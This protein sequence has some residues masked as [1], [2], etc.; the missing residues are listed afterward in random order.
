LEEA[1][2]GVIDFDAKIAKALE[3]ELATKKGSSGQA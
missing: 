1:K 3:L 2:A